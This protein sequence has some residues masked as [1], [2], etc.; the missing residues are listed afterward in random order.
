MKEKEIILITGSSG[1]IGRKL[2]S[3][4]SRDFHVV[5]LDRTG[6]KEALPGVY[7]HDV[8]VT[9]EENVSLVL[10]EIKENFGNKLHSV[11]HLVAF[12]DFKGAPDERYEKITING[13]QFLLKSLRENFE[14]KKFIFSSSL[15]VYAPVEPGGRIRDESPLAPSWPYPQSKVVAEKVIKEE[16]GNIPVINLR[17][18]G[19]YDDTCHSPT[20]S[21]QIMRIYEGWFSSFMFPGNPDTGQSFLHLEDLNEAIVGFVKLQRPLSQ[22]ENY[23]LGEEDVI[24]FRELQQRTGMLIHRRPWPVIRIPK[25]LAKTGASMMEHL[26]IMREPFIKPWMVSH[27]DEHFAVD[28]T[29]IKQT[30]NWEPKRKLRNT[31]PVMIN[32]LMEDPDK[33]YKINKIQKPFYR[34]LLMI[35]QEGERNYF[36]AAVMTIFLGLLVFANPFTFGNL[37]Q[38]E[39]LSQ[40]V[41]G[42]LVTILATFSLFPTL[43]WLRWVNATIGC[44]LLFSPLVFFTGSDAAYSNDTFIGGL[45]ILTSAYTPS[46]SRA[47]GKPPGWSYNP[48][49]AG[50]RIPIMF[51]GFLGFLA[52]RYLAAF[53]LGHIE[54]V[55]DPFFGQDT[56]TVLTSDVSKAFPISDAGLGALTY[57]LDVIAASIGGRDRWRSLPWAVI[58]FGLM[59]IP[60]GVTSITLIM[61]QPI[62]VGAW[63]TICLFTAFIM[64]LMV[65]PAVDEVLASV[66]F[67]I[68]RK[69]AGDNFWKVFWFGSD[70]KEEF[71]TPEI[72][73]EGNIIH[74]Y[75]CTML[76]IWLMFAPTVLGV[77]GLASSSTYIVAALVATFSIISMSEVA[78][79]TRLIN[80][81]LGIW[82]ALS[83]WMLSGMNDV[84][85]WNSFIVG[86]LLIVLSLPRGK[87]R[88]V[89][90]PSDKIIHW[91]PFRRT[92]GS[93]GR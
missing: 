23:V 55:W 26:P 75:I 16:Q 59:I 83:G 91:T 76:A 3:T 14:V 44:W 61:L 80:I 52:A 13:T 19:V 48:S 66:Q 37:E 15:L 12:Y 87:I 73:K 45:I 30:L 85:R 64:L 8:D 11:I 28:I 38:G 1:F 31:L 71:R 72:R 65:P 43:R 24:T 20:I 42:L 25:F 27:S 54:S 2:A 34:N 53:Q 69:K 10:R 21:Q 92:H 81:P 88:Q 51:L 60:S 93:H 22:F 29:R 4:L 62:S 41:S 67:L 57:L 82:L 79:I 5:G 9:S 58:L 6:P 39:F 47:L 50:Q 86:I 63:C 7:H 70:V 78:R 90:G 74:L 84:A 49:T 68:R 77:E 89:Y 35:G 36:L 46:M 18:A 32:G 33:W 40:L 56:A 17:I